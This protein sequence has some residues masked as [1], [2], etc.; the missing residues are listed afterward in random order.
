M[1]RREV[2]GVFGAAAAW[3]ITA[4]AQNPEP[5]RRVGVLMGGPSNAAS[6]AWITAFEQTLQR[7]GWAAGR[8]LQ[9]D[10]RWGANNGERVAAFA[11]ELIAL[12][13]DV[14]VAGPTN[15]LVPLRKQT[16]TI[17][18]VFVQVS[19]PL[20]RGIVK[21]L[22]RPT[23]NV[24]GFS[25]L[26]FSLIGKYMQLLKEVAPRTT[27]IAV[28]IHVSNAVSAN[29]YRMFEKLAPSFAIEPIIAPIRE[30]D[31]IARTIQSLSLKPNGGLIVP[32]DTYVSAPDVRKIIVGLTALHR[33]PALYTHPGFV[34]DGG[35]MSYSIDQADQFRGAASYVA[36]ILK[37]EAPS[38]LPIQQPSR[39]E[40]LINLKT[41]KSLGLNVPLQL[42]ANANELLE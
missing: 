23:D 13:P 19:D 26:E 39:F 20:G 7:L 28:I 3:P 35:M 24:T 5:L 32:G 30:R 10:I 22:S 18:I 25:N 36:R 40:L 15:A 11:K 38:D 17:P 8:N 12:K 2:F 42:Q 34:R 14:I 1:R 31:D 6:G 9:I 4:Y 16:Q 27:R 21:S 41:T 37:G 29:W 33:L